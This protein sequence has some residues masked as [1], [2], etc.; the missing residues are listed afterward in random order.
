MAAG[1]RVSAEEVLS[2]LRRL[3]LDTAQNALL[4][5]IRVLDHFG[6]ARRLLEFPGQR[7]FAPAGT[8]DQNLHDER[9]VYVSASSW[10]RIGRDP[11]PGTENVSL[12]AVDAAHQ[13]RK[14]RTPVNTIAMPCSSAA[15]TI[16]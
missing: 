10:P 6:D 16:S 4:T 15:A 7:M 8:D 1:D 2:T 9:T 11:T 3:R 14:C 12:F 5:H 13:W